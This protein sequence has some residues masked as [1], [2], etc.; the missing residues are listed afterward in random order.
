VGTYLAAGYYATL[1]RMTYAEAKKYLNK[2]K[3]VF[4]VPQ[5][6]AIKTAFGPLA[7]R[8]LEDQETFM[9]MDEVAFK[10][11][12]NVF[13]MPGRKFKTLP[14]R[15]RPRA[16]LSPGCMMWALRPKQSI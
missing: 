16:R 1:R 9:A 4:F 2:T 8:V 12:V 11:L 14:P 13:W 6:E 7:D 3:S 5:A 10:N 15:S